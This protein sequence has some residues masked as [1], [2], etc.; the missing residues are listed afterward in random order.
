M[1]STSPRPYPLGIYLDI[2]NRQWQLAMEKS[3][4]PIQINK[5]QWLVL[6]AM[7]E[8]GNGCNLT[9]IAD[10]L[11]MEISTCSRAISWLNHKK[12]IERIEDKNDKRA[13]VLHITNQGKEML[14]QL[15]EAAQ[16]V[17]KKM[18]VNITQEQYALFQQVLDAI[19]TQA[20]EILSQNDPLD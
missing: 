5:P 16:E 8:L 6:S 15:D 13:K 11:A 7:D 3:L 20:T 18:L 14:Y 12:Y 19:K 17:R 4:S 9:Q 10:F 2:T 1:K